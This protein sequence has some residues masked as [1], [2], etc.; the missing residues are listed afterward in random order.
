MKTYLLSIPESVRQFSATLNV[1]AILCRQ[2]WQ[3]LDD[4]DAKVLYIFRKDG[5]LLIST[6]GTV[7][8]AHWEYLKEN[9]TIL[10][11]S[12]DG[13]FLFHPVFYD[14]I[15][16]A[17]QQDGTEM[18]LAMVN[19]NRVSNFL[20][21]TIKSM[22]QY[23]CN[24]AERSKEVTSERVHE[25]ERI[26]LDS[27]RREQIESEHEA[28]IS[29]ATSPM[30]EKKSKVV[31][32]SVTITSLICFASLILGLQLSNDI[33]LFIIPVCV[34]IFSMLFTVTKVENINS[35]INH[36]KEDIISKYL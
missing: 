21:L 4:Q 6:D 19:V 14:E 31:R 5:T 30:I 36:I 25:M 7:V 12:R 24:V 10:I 22:N 28:E 33:L 13:S 3:C 29:E 17:L 9:H 16:L 34:L 18:F 20:Q 23:I 8:K 32:N 26:R 1:T 15:V 35:N 11:D 2:A 27:K